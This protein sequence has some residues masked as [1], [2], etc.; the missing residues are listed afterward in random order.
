VSVSDGVAGMSSPLLFDNDQVTFT[1]TLDRASALTTSVRFTT[2][3]GTYHAVVDY[4]PV[5]QIVSFP[6]GTTSKTVVVTLINANCT[7]ADQ[8]FFGNISAPVNATIARPQG[9]AVVPPDS[10]C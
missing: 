5:D 9:I 8:T 2:S 7:F 1:I 10:A 6:P 4:V 3:D